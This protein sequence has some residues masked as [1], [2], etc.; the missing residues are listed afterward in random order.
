MTDCVQANIQTA[1]L[2]LNYFLQLLHARN[3][4]HQ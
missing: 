2:F 3:Q 4:D 1:L